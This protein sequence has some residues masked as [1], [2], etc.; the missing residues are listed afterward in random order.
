[1]DSEG[2]L[3][4]MQVHGKRIEEENWKQ[5]KRKRKNLPPEKQVAAIIVVSWL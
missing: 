3:A 2:H 4:R 5:R 1:M